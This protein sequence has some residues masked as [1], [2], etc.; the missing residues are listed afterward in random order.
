MD[1]RCDVDGL[2]EELLRTTELMDQL[3]EG[4]EY[5]VGEGSGIEG[6]F[7]RDFTPTPFA[8]LFPL[9]I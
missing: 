3:L 8:L 7:R 4:G 5:E 1:G 2:Y 9:T 6:R